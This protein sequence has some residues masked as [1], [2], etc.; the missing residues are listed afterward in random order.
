MSVATYR[1]VSVACDPRLYPFFR[2]TTEKEQ[3]HRLDQLFREHL[4]PMLTRALRSWQ[5]SA[6]R[7][8][9]LDDVRLEAARELTISLTR[10]HHAPEQAGIRHLPAYVN[11][12]VRHAFQR[13]SKL[14]NPWKT[15]ELLETTATY[16]PNPAGALHYRESLSLLWAEI[17]LLPASQQAALL[18]N[19]QTSQGYPL[20]PSLFCHLGIATPEEITAVLEEKWSHTE[21]FEEAPLSDHTIA[22]RLGLTQREV[23]NL[24]VSARRRLQR[25]AASQL[26]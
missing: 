3:R 24:R 7:S 25:R 2:A 9:S 18:M 12:V 20:P 4:N 21:I 22:E 5:R 19:L 15:E 11:T 16:T 6:P 14:E 8:L 1:P 13:L 17:C 23:I 10:A 26:G